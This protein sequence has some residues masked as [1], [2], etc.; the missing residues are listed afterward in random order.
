MSG[1]L[2][3]ASEAGSSGWLSLVRKRHLVLASSSPRRAG[4]LT[5]MGIPFEVRPSNVPETGLETDPAARA[6][7]LAAAK[8]RKVAEKHGSGLVLGGDTEVVLDGVALGKPAGPE[9]ALDMLLRLRGRSHEV[10]TGLH[11]LDGPTG[12]SCS[13][14]EKTIVTMRSFS[15]TEAAAYAGSGD[16]LD[17]AGAYG[18]QGPAAVLVSRIEGCFYNVVGLPLSRLAELME[19]LWGKMQGRVE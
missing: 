19:E 8:A 15:D 12:L 14:V 2:W 11:L 6:L 18:I 5:L 17:K 10:L 3:G 9:E 13:A 16:P 4:L 1:F 7:G